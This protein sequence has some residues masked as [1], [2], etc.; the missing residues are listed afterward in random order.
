MK[1]LERE[2]GSLEDDLSFD[3]DHVRFIL[4]PSKF[5]VFLIYLII[6]LCFGAAGSYRVWYELFKKLYMNPRYDVWAVYVTGIPFAITFIYGIIALYRRIFVH[7]EISRRFIRVVSGMI[8]K[9]VENIDMKRVTDT[10]LVNYGVYS[11]IKIVSSDKS[12]PNLDMSFLNSK[13]AGES[14]LFI[15][16]VAISSR[17]ELLL[18]TAK[19]KK[20]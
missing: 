2:S 17:T 14:F 18:A 20:S 11:N 16:D 4:K 13:I 6:P 19:V 8:I 5:V 10:A 15:N 1:L 7:Y 9:K 12:C 3:G